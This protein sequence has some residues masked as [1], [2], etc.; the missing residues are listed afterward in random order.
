MG[1][2]EKRDGYYLG[3]Y[4]AGDGTWP[5]VKT[6]D[7]ETIRFRTKRAAVNAANDEEA[8][9]R[10]GRRVRSHGPITFGDWANAWYQDLDLA[11]ST[12]QNYRHHLEE[13]LLPEFED[14]LLTSVTTGRIGEWERK[15]RRAG[16]SQ[17]SVRTWRTTLS[18][19][20]GDAATEELIDANPAVR[21]R[22]R[23]RRAG[24][25]H[26]RG[27]EKATTSPLGAL[28]IA[29]RAA[30][31]TGRNDEF[32]A[33]QLMYWTGLRWGELVGLEAKFVRPGS[34]R[35]EW[36]LWEDDTSNF[37]RLPPKD[38]SYRDIDL[39]SWL[40][41]LV[42]DHLSHNAAQPC[43]CHGNRYLFAGQRSIHPR[44][45]S[46]SDWIFDPATT[47]WFPPRGKRAPRRPVPIAAEPWP[48]TVE[49]GRGNAARATACWLPIAPDLTPH[50]L[51]HSHKTLMVEHRVPEIL[52]HERLGH[53]LEG[54]GGVY[55]HI[56][57]T[58]RDDL[59]NLLTTEWH[60]A[61]AARHAMHPTSPVIA[62][63]EL[64]QNQAGRTP[65]KHQAL[66]GRQLNRL[67][68]RRPNSNES[69]NQAAKEPMEP[70]RTTTRPPADMGP[71][72]L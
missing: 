9:R 59:L 42:N 50:G 16:Y 39:P 27:P 49:R 24:R 72:I 57:A 63:N 20:L 69:A 41:T 71:H 33:I 38:D 19:I 12:M 17:S 52:S 14:E 31:L 53:Q 64:L 67:R 58:M 13:H 4:S 8:R 25:R 48:G 46:F 3:R 55:S 35:V 2:A 43:P 18:T 28:L 34:L 45:S 40:T 54:I 66:G 56:T 62:L 60:A 21:S 5:L 15:E 70:L 7:G 68:A 6:E 47:G 26:D 32:A 30:I 23:G 29:E 22:R 65:P 61:L 10:Q 44:R 37:H 11:Q 36:Q 1:Y 51:R